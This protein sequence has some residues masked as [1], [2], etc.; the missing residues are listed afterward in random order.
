[1]NIKVLSILDRYFNNPSVLTLIMTY[2]TL[3]R[4]LYHMRILKI[5]KMSSS[6]FGLEN[7]IMVKIDKNQ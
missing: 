2:R 5:M 4:L 6:L 3:S 1:M 7:V